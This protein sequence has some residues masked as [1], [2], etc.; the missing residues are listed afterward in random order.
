MQ[1]SDEGPGIN[2]ADLPILFERFFK[3]DRARSRGDSG[4]G[5]GLSI[6]KKLVELHGG[7]IDAALLKSGG[8][9]VTIQLPLAE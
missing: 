7:Q 3:G 4:S 1:V 2:P 6:V 8:L 5:L 9:Q